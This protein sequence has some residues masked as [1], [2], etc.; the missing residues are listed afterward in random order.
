[1]GGQAGLLSYVWK[2]IRASRHSLRA[3]IKRGI[4]PFSKAAKNCFHISTAKTVFTICSYYIIYRLS[5][6]T[7]L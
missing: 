1:M 3:G 4:I 7:S 6:S 5:L 2:E